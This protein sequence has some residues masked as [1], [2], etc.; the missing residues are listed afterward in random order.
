MNATKRR[1]PVLAGAASRKIALSN[2]PP[3]HLQAVC[4]GWLPT[5]W[6]RLRCGI[7]SSASAASGAGA[8]GAAIWRSIREPSA[9]VLPLIPFDEALRPRPVRVSGL[10]SPVGYSGKL[11]LAPSL[12]RLAKS[13]CNTLLRCSSL[14]AEMR[15]VAGRRYQI[16]SVMI[17]EVIN[18]LLAVLRGEDR[19]PA[20]F[21]PGRGLGRDPDGRL[22]VTAKVVSTARWQQVAANNCSWS[23]KESRRASH[24]SRPS[25]KETVC[26]ITP[27]MKGVNRTRA[28]QQA[29]L[30]PPPV[31]PASGCDS[32]QDIG[33]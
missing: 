1:H 19:L 12:P 20:S 27:R 26:L 5:R 8:A 32:M 25:S 18:I 6:D 15:G 3:K 23:R 28:N 30:V 22:S 24:H 9:L 29:A 2:P 13:G 33:C 17:I 4:S 10:A 14:I 11:H 7:R 31:G 16:T 21:V